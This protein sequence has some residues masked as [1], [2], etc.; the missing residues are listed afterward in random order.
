MRLFA[1]FVIAV[2][3]FSGGVHAFAEEHYRWALALCA[4]ALLMAG[5]A[6]WFSWKLTQRA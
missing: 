3:L 4:A 2:L 6:G 5:L 1:L